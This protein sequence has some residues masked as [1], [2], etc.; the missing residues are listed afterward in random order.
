MQC[1]K[2]LSFITSSVLGSC[3]CYHAQQHVHY[4]LVWLPFLSH[5]L[6]SDTVTATPHCC[7]GNIPT[8]ILVVAFGVPITVL[9]N[10]DREVRA[11]SPKP[12]L[13]DVMG[14]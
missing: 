9:K 1:L 8:L 12:K 13:C 3:G 7:H 11:Q 14:P 2:L 6:F 10:E 4:L 5:Q